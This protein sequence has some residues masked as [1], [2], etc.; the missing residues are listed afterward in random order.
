ML[1]AILGSFFA[2]LV[3]R[4]PEPASG[5]SR[6]D[7][8]DHVLGPS[9][10]VPVL[11]YIFNR[12]RCRTCGG[13][14]APTHIAIELLS[15]LVGLIAFAALPLPSAL[16]GLFFGC[17]LVALAWLDALHLTLPDRL[18]LPL[19]PL[20]L[21][22]AWLAQGSLRDALIGAAVG[23]G[24]LAA[25]AL[26]YRIIRGRDGMGGG[27]PK[28][29]GAI[30]AWIGWIGL[31]FVLLGASVVGLGYAL[32]TRANATSELPL[33]TFLCLAAWPVWFAL[34]IGGLLPG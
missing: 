34:Q 24:G 31:P 6:C 4:W 12:G 30:G 15:A 1:G 25:L 9:E 17:V 5:R 26:G 8:C 22:Q 19:L 28:L 14:I 21:C 7:R 11:T 23:Y 10:L 27:D 13:R 16:F 20:G 29:F 33:G 2:T 3:L 18:V 32:W